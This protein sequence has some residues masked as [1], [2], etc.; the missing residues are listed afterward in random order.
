MSCTVLKTSV[1]QATFYGQKQDQDYRGACSY[2]EDAARSMNM[3]W[4][5]GAALSLAINKDM[6]DS[7]KACG[8][9]VMYRGAHA[10]IDGW[11]Q[12]AAGSSGAEVTGP[13]PHLRR[14]RRDRR[15]ARINNPVVHGLHK[16]HLPRVQQGRP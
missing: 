3:S 8:T 1:A 2:S 5:L 16:Q 13:V 10:C 14:W 11:C 12:R 6:F 9:C 15:Y 4:T 7:S